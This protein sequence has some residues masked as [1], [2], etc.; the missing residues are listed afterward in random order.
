MYLP[1]LQPVSN[2]N[3]RISGDVKI[4]PSAVLAPGVI[5][6]A[7][8]ES[9][10]V[11]GA[12]VCIGMGTI[13]NAYQGCIEIETGAILGAGVLVIG[14]GKIGTNACVGTATTIFN[15]SVPSMAA[16]APGSLVGDTSRQV[17][18]MVDRAVGGSYQELR[19]GSKV[20]KASPPSGATISNEGKEISEQATTNNGFQAETNQTTERVGETPVESS[21][22]NGENAENAPV[23]LELETNS[24][25]AQSSKKPIVGQVYINE[26]MLTLFPHNQYLNRSTP[27]D[28]E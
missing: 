17:K 19:D 23:D 18:N 13:L 11:I 25:K 12:E 9:S 15:A 26:L 1:P 6:Q 22:S 14:A 24:S 16:I 2:S 27:K 20:G 5:L 28:E 21:A 4:H 10:I 3:I 8:P 7:A